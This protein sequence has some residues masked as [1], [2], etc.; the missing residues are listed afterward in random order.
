MAK[1]VRCP[2]HGNPA[3]KLCSGTKFYQYQPTDRGWMPF[4]CPTCQGAPASARRGCVTCRGGV[5]VDPASPP[6]APGW[7]G[8]FRKMWK[9]LFGGG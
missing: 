9:L 6:F 5:W 8:E 2:C 4:A 1:S 7:K 3:C